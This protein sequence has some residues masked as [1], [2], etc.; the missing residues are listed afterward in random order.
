MSL[1]GAQRRGSH[2]HLYP[3][4]YLCSYIG[5]YSIFYVKCYEEKMRATEYEIATHCW[6]SVRND[7]EGKAGVSVEKKDKYKDAGIS[8]GI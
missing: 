6:R 1:R 3:H 5:T 8:E 7:K 4:L 2:I